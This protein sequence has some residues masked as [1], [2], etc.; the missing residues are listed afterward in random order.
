MTSNDSSKQSLPG[1]RAI[2]MTI[3]VRMLA[4]NVDQGVERLN[5]TLMQH[6]QKCNPQSPLIDYT[7]VGCKPV[8]PEATLQKAESSLGQLQF[9]VTVKALNEYWQ[10]RRQ[11]GYEP[12]NGDHRS[13]CVAESLEDCLSNID[14]NKAAETCSRGG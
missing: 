11:G 1:E 14:L 9:D 7:I 3:F 6:T 10:W 12:C 8:D 4:Q 2:S 5:L 13:D